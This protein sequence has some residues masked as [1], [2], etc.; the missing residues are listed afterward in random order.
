MLTLGFGCK[1]KAVVVRLGERGCYCAQFVRHTFF[2]AF[3]GSSSESKGENFRAKEVQPGSEEQ[4]PLGKKVVDPTGGG[5]AFLGGF[6]IGLL[7]ERHPGGLTEFEVGCIYGSVAASFAIEQVGMPTLTHV[8][9]HRADL[10]NG[11]SVRHRMN[12]FEGKLNIPPLSDEQLQ[13]AS[14]YKIDVYDQGDWRIVRKD[15]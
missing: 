6:C 7:N 8:E 11:E 14:L 15:A 3:Y 2:P 10:W 4:N 13:K 5:N 12:H 1:P 9:T